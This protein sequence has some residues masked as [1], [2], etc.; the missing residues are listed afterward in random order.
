MVSQRFAWSLGVGQ[1]LEVLSDNIKPLPETSPIQVIET[2]ASYKP[3][4]NVRSAGT[5]AKR[6]TWTHLR[7]K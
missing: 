7:L 3:E 2:P 1:F 4:Q 6:N 5:T